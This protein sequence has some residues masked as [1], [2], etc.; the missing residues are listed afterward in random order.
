MSDSLY[1]VLC[2]DRVPNTLA[3][4]HANHL[5]PP[6]NAQL[7]AQANTHMQ[8]HYVA[9]A[10]PFLVPPAPSATALHSS[11]PN[12]GR[13]TPTP[14]NVPAAPQQHV[15]QQ[16]QL[17]HPSG[18]V[19]RSS[20]HTVQMRTSPQTTAT[21]QT[22]SPQTSAAAQSSPPTVTYAGLQP[23]IQTKPP[24]AQRSVSSSG[25]AQTFGGLLGGIASESA[26]DISTV[27]SATG[28]TGVV[29][30]R[31]SFSCDDNDSLR[32]NSE[33]P[34]TA[35]TPTA[36]ETQFPRSGSLGSIQINTPML[37]PKPPTTLLASTTTFGTSG[38]PPSLSSPQMYAHSQQGSSPLPPPPLPPPSSTDRPSNSH[39]GNNDPNVQ[40]VPL[41][42]SVP[43]LP[44]PPSQSAN[45]Q[46]NT[47]SYALSNPNSLPKP[48]MPAYLQSPTQAY[49]YTQQQQQPYGQAF[50]LQPPPTSA[51]QSIATPS[52]SDYLSRMNQP[53][54]RKSYSSSNLNT[55]MSGNT[56]ARST[57]PGGAASTGLSLG[58]TKSPSLDNL[59]SAQSLPSAQ[60][61]SSGQT[62]SSASTY[63]S[64]N[65]RTYEHSQSG[66][67]SPRQQKRRI[68][69]AALPRP[70]KLQSDVVYHTRS[71]TSRYRTFSELFVDFTG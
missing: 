42:V 67:N 40:K 3:H 51:Q 26:N 66:P 59:T 13:Q 48:P 12:S 2:I 64:A 52:S 57:S 8:K 5:H 46:P 56:N 35:Q 30:A 54:A 50:S 23:S 24:S 45:K 27:S 41:S 18:L 62:Q 11:P 61:P 31:R 63:S 39:N 34:P 37:P 15:P 60:T 19:H 28:S 32:A 7:P 43:P 38:Q 58:R 20:P 65:T 6:P 47:P 16:A 36:T 9:P 25:I 53:L 69:A 68:A 14:P 55:M 22:I 1:L 4:P 70:V 10:S 21:A 44:P 71:G 29:R 17:P 49:A 33:G